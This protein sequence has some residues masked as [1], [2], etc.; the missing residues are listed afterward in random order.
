MKHTQS[1]LGTGGG[2]GVLRPGL[3]A[4]A[5]ISLGLSCASYQWKRREGEGARLWKQT[6]DS[7][8][9]CAREASPCL[10]DVAA[11]QRL[12]QDGI[13]SNMASAR[14][15]DLRDCTSRN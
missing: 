6:K 1:I 14:R 2:Y 8:W 12:L 3:Q 10:C 11:G 4:Q 9:G 13:I 15:R 5:L 7:D